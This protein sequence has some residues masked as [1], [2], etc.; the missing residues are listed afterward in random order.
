MFAQEAKKQFP[1]MLERF[2]IF[3]REQEH[4][5]KAGGSAG[6]GAMDLASYVEF[7]RSHRLVTRAHKEALVAVRAFWGLL[8]HADVSYVKLSKA[9]DRI[10]VGSFGERWK[11]WAAW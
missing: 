5:Q 6:K 7:Q 3:C 11:G 4:T 8:L 1:G 2:A 9:L 10:E